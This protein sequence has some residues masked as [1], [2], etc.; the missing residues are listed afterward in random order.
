MHGWILEFGWPGQTLRKE[1]IFYTCYTKILFTES[2]FN[3]F[4]VDWEFAS[5]EGQF[6]TAKFLKSV[7]FKLYFA[8]TLVLL[9]VTFWHICTELLF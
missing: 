3:F 1:L 4:Y 9:K 2:K 7:D 5:R 6:H 8:Y